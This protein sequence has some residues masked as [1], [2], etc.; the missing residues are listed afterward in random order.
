MEKTAHHRSIKKLQS[1]VTVKTDTA[2][3]TKAMN[4][5]SSTKQWTSG[6][7]PASKKLNITRNITRTSGNGGEGNVAEISDCLYYLVCILCF[8]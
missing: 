3:T 8:Y 1:N 7:T 4:G 2:T 6:G 5:Q